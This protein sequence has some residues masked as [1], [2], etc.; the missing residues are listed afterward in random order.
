MATIPDRDVFITVRVPESIRDRLTAL[1]DRRE[2]TQLAEIRL[3]IKAHLDR[4]EK[5][6]A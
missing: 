5:A 1:A 6:A 4:E 3:A 2:R